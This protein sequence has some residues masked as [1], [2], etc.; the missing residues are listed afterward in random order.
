MNFL[1]F[2]EKMMDLVCFTM[3]QVYAWQPNFDR[4][5]VVRWVKKGYLIRL[6]QSLYTFP[7]FKGKIDFLYYFANR[8]YQPSFISLH[9]ALSFYGIIPE[10]VMQINSITSLKTA[11]FVNVLGEYSYNNVK[12]NLMF[13]YDLKPIPGN[14]TIRFASAE[15]ALLDLLYLYPQ[16]NSKQDMEEL[17]LDEDYLHNELNVEKLMNLASGFESKALERRMKTLIKTYGL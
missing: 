8:I 17:R 13:G 10:A 11:R 14:I 15:R 7:E 6:R 9:T 12:G 2:K 4:S 3:N 5:N 1:E 16:Y